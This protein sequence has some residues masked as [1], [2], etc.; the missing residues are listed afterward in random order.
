MDE[1]NAELPSPAPAR[2]L[3]GHPSSQRAKRLWRSALTLLTAVAISASV[4]AIS[5]RV[6]PRQFAR[7]GYP[8]VF[9]ISLLG[10]ATIIL[11]APSL[12]VVSVVGSVLNPF[13]VGLCAGIGEALGE[14]TGY[15]AGYSGRAVVEDRERYRRVVEWT[16]KYGLWVVLA[17]SIFP[18]PLFDLAGIAAGALKVP[19]LK[20]LLVCWIGKTIKTILFAWGGRAILF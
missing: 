5:R 3:A 11:P 4:F 18:N 12:A 10:N 13:L 1:P 6:E 2:R 16:Q 8:G 17:L 19:P 15:L 20:F 7:Y 9:I 14:M